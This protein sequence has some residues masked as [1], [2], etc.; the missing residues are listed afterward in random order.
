MKGFES[1]VE[2]LGLKERTVS[3]VDVRAGRCKIES[4]EKRRQLPSPWRCLR[5]TGFLQLS[6]AVYHLILVLS[7]P[8]V[9]IPRTIMSRL[10]FHARSDII[11]TSN[12]KGARL[13]VTRMRYCKSM[14]SMVNFSHATHVYRV[15]ACRTKS[16]E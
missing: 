13:L 9:C 7:A 2:G 3:D 5:R 8:Y 15:F 1:E 11:A 10:S 4:D 12:G 16:P 6:M 14:M